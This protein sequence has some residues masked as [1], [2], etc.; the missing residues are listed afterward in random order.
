M[1]IDWL[2][3]CSTPEAVEERKKLVRS[4]Q[5]ALTKLHD[6]LNKKL[7]EYEESRERKADY[8]SPNWA[9]KQADYN[10][11]IRLLK[12]IL[13]LLDQEENNK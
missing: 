2:R 12:E 13:T 10:G 6:V 7:T 11:R 4:G 1:R 5:P 8:D 3:D 9:H